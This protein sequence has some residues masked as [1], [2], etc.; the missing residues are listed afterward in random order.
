M[1][2]GMWDIIL[3]ELIEFILPLLHF[4]K[5]NLLVRSHPKIREALRR[6]EEPYLSKA[7]IIHRLRWHT[8]MDGFANLVW[9]PSDYTHKWRVPDKARY[10]LRALWEMKQSSNKELYAEMQRDFYYNGR[11]QSAKFRTTLFDSTPWL[12]LIQI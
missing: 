8:T 9:Q 12:E 4:G 2:T 5:F 10:I 3:C 7:A 1:C 6:I 11:I